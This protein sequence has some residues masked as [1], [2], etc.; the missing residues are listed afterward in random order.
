MTQERNLTVTDFSF[1]SPEDYGTGTFSLR[2]RNTT[3]EV[4]THFSTEGKQ[5][6]LEQFMELIMN[7]RLV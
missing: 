3:Y 1:L 4:N 2:L 5:S 7:D 6:V